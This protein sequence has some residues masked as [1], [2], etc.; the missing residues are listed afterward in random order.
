MPDSNSVQ[1]GRTLGTRF[2]ERNLDLVGKI[3]QRSV[4]PAA[5]DVAHGKRLPS[6]LVVDLDPTTVCDL[7]C[8]ECIST[9]VLHHGQIAKDRIVELAHELGESQVRAVILIGGGEPLLHRSVG[10]IIEVLHESGIQLGLVTNGTQ[11]HRYIDQLAAMMSWVRVSM[12]AGTPDTYQAF[13]PSRGKHSA[14]PQVVENMRLLASRKRGRLGYSFLLMQRFD[15]DGKVTDSNYDEVYQAGVLARDI[16]CDYFEV[17][18]MLDEDHYTVNQ[19]LE[20]IEAVEE[21][22]ARLR[23][24]AD[25]S[26]HIL[27]SSNWQAVRRSAAPEQ[28]KDYHTCSVAELRTTIT[29]TGVFICPY[30]RG[31]PKGRIGDIQKMSFAEMWSSADTTVID[32]SED[33]RFVCARHGTNQEI[34]LLKERPEPVGLAEDF[35]PFI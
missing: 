29:P 23:L 9:Q 18:A 22:I 12:D 32:P 1:P 19:R 3:Y 5:L 33:C 16:G 28:P 4:H 35:D 25:D 24:L 8:P 13:R 34:P 17:K 2:V 26:F 10:R 20:D 31:N 7:A 11:I 21:Q 14:F 6:P 15:S 27:H 30:H